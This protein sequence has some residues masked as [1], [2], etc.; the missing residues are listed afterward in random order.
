MKILGCNSGSSSLKFS[1]FEAD[2]ELLL[3][4]G[5]CGGDG[6][7]FTAGVGENSAQVRELACQ[8]LGY[9]GLKL[10]CAAKRQ[11]QTGRRCCLADFPWPSSRHLYGAW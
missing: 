6:L 1:L 9:L 3:A 11:M 8:K 10:D 7:V 2:E 5:G 4:D